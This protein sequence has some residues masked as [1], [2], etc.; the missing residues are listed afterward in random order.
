M[1]FNFF[2]M[3]DRRFGPPLDG[4]TR[5]ELLQRSI[6][7]GAGLLLSSSR[8]FS[9]TRAAGKR[10][11]VVGAGFAGVTAAYE[12]QSAGYDVTVV[13]ARDR[14]GGRV[15]TLERFVKDK[16]VEAGGEMVGANHPTWAA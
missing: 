12:L 1:P 2:Q 4:M 11:I 9:A 14:I 5:R 13:E 7:A 16:T 6:A 8:G 3:L 15:H 10:V